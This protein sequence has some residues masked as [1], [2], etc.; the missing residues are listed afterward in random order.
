MAVKGYIFKWSVPMK[1]VLY[2]LVL[3]IMCEIFQGS[4]QEKEIN[5]KPRHFP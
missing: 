4:S 1:M 5:D 3:F 2:K